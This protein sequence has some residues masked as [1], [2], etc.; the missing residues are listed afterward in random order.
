MPP[1]YTIS[2]D[3][4]KQ[5]L[6][7]TVMKWLRNTMAD[8]FSG[9]SPLFAKLRAKGRLDAGN[10]GERLTVPMVHPDSSGPQV[11]GSLDPY[12]A[13][14]HLPMTG[15]VRSKFDW[16]AYFMPVSIPQRDDQLNSGLNAKVQLRKAVMDNARM[17]FLEG[18]NQHMWAAE[19]DPKSAGAEDQLA[20]LCTLLN[21]G[22]TSAVGGATAP[23]LPI[24][25]QASNTNEVASWT[26]ANSGV[27]AY[28]TTAT[29]AVTLVGGIN[30]NASKGTYFSVPVL[31][32]TTPETFSR[33][34]ISKVIV[35]GQRGSDRPD[36]VI[37]PRSH[38]VGLLSILQGQ[39]ELQP[40]KMTDYG[41]QAFQ[42]MGCDVVFDD[43]CPT[44]APGPTMLAINTDKLM[45]R[46]NT[47]SPEITQSDDPERPLLVW[48]M[49]WMCQLVP[50]VL[51]RGLGSR[52]ANMAA[53]T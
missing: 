16:A 5:I 26:S 21:K 45:F 50:E 13:A 15:F 34:L 43:M 24:V 44:A 14:A 20:S 46:C 31:N 33:T 18:V 25:E 29:N 37:L 36:L 27:G 47:Q 35:M 53:P 42:Y 10:M 23:P 4:E 19:E 11:A 41:Y 7:T 1:V 38:Y 28:R 49:W 48:K 3:A 22:T 2:A 30:R 8:A 9:H 52:H 40:S 6:V 39:Q 17:R 12:I 51:G 32:P